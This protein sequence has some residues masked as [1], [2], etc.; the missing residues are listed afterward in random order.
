MKRVLVFLLG[1]ALIASLCLVV[2]CQ[3]KET[4]SE[5]GEKTSSYSEQGMAPAEK[6]VQE[7]AEKAAGHG[8]KAMKEETEKAAGGYGQ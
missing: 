1:A 6:A 3:K 5:P 7:T 4:A 8:E 2:S